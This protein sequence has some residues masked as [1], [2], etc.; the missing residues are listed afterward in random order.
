MDGS[1][2]EPRQKI[3]ARYGATTLAELSLAIASARVFP[4]IKRGLGHSV[5]CG[6]VRRAV[7]MKATF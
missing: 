2:Y 6:A 5:S 3:L 7:L 1:E 4:T